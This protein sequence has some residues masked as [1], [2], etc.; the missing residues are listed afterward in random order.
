M[1]QLNISS[2]IVDPPSSSASAEAEESEVALDPSSQDLSVSEHGRDDSCLPVIDLNFDS[3]T[4][5]AAPE[6]V[7]YHFKSTVSLGV[8]PHKL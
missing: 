6:E 8:T 1:L 7:Y 3:L 5:T 4:L 2:E